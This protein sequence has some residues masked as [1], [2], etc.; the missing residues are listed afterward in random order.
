MNALSP[1]SPGKPAHIHIL[2]GTSDALILC[3]TLTRRGVPYSLSVASDT[4]AALA[5]DLGGELQVGRMDADAMA[6]W[7][8]NARWVIDASHPYAELAS[9]NLAAAC[10][11]LGLPLTRY[12]R[13]SDIATINHPLLLPVDSVEQACQTAAALGERIMLTTGSK[14]LADYVRWLPGKTLIARVLPLAGIL[15]ECATLGLGVNQV[16]AM[17]GPFSHELNV[18]LYRH[19]RP[20]VMITK[21][22]GREGGYT[23]KVR[24]CLEMNIPCVVIRRPVMHWDDVIATPEAFERRLNQWLDAL[25]V[26]T[27]EPLRNP[28]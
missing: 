28:V 24:P 18:A 6:D 10:A 26:P 21:E 14:Q 23:E 12:E 3:R 1:V 7:L 9:H 11:E 4:G 2:G 8:R 25:D 5:G 27:A 17:T 22:S 13:P 20:Q 16:I 19:F 15:A